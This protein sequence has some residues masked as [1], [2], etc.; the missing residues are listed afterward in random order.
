[1]STCTELAPE[2]AEALTHSPIAQLRRLAVVTDDARVTITGTVSSYYLK[3]LA[4]ETVLS[5][6]GDRE[7]CNDVEVCPNAH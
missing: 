1:M 7:L 6:I 2:P 3:Q 4:Q 5:L